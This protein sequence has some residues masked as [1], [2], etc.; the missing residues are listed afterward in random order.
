MSTLKPIKRM[1]FYE[2]F[3]ENYHSL[4]DYALGA[5]VYF[6]YS[7]FYKRTKFWKGFVSFLMGTVTAQFLGPEICKIFPSLGVPFISF[8][9]GLLGMR[10]AEFIMNNDSW[11]AAITKTVKF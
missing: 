9:C 1:S 2:H 11:K 7:M 10:I 3:L 6:V 8:V 4:R 5:G